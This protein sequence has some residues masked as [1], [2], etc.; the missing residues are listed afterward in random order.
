[1]YPYG[2]VLGMSPGE[3]ENEPGEEGYDE[4][5]LHKTLEYWKTM[6]SRE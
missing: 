3:A 4:T 5:Q 6:K 2:T 1:M